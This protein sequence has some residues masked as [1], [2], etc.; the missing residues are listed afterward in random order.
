MEAY[1]ATAP[2]K[3][4]AVNE[5]KDNEVSCNVIKKCFGSLHK[6]LLH[7]FN[8]SLRNGTFPD[9]LKI[10]R[11]TPLFKNGSGLDLRNCRLVSV[12]PCVSKIIEKNHVKPSL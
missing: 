10:A 6:P 9:E 5:L 12:L 1:N 4:L 8:A 2:E 3:Y 7:I 11:V